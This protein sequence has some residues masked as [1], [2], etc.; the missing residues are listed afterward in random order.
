MIIPSVI[1]SETSRNPESVYIE[2]KINEFPELNL[3]FQNENGEIVN[4]GDFLKYKK[5]III[6]PAYYNCPRLCTL[7]YNG[8]VEVIEKQ[9]SLIPGKDYLIISI[10]MAEEEDATLAKEK[11]KNY[12]NFFE[13][14]KVS[15][16]DW[17]F[18]VADK[19]YKDNPKK[20]LYSLGYYYKKDGKDYS[21]PAAIIF[22]TPEGKI[23]KYLYGIEFS[24]KDFRFALI[25]ASQGKAGTIV[26]AFLMSCF[27][28]DS[29]QG[30]YEPFAWG[31]I[32]LGSILILF[33]IVFIIGILI[34][35]EKKKT[36]A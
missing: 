20:F 15:S 32:R 26:D 12:R 31:F 22:L 34:F 28:Y 29:V 3:L 2:Q 4:L 13:K 35:F 8:L 18:L 36:V 11:A 5:P 27:R 16:N 21:H 6:A 1:F 17:I 30:K 14:F 25:D 7:V 23:S 10:S 24:E 19:H 33:F 9:K